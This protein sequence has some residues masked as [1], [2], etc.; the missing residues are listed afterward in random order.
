MHDCGMAVGTWAWQTYDAHTMMTQCVTFYVPALREVNTA[1][2][3]ELDRKMQ[4]A[5]TLEQVAS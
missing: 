4:I 5:R 1:N 3:N 2:Q